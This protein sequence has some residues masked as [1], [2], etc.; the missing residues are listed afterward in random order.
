MKRITL[1]EAT[2]ESSA[3]EWGALNE[4]WMHGGLASRSKLV[5]AYRIQNKGLIA[6]SVAM[7]Q[8]MGLRLSG[9]NFS[10]GV[11]R[12]GQLS[13]RMLWHGTRQASGLLDI[14]SDG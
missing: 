5:G 13:V 9:E 10:D 3:R 11:T 8:A 1:A 2:D 7:R 14:C 6:G 12:D 4:L